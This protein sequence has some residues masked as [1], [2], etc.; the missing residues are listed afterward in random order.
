LNPGS[1]YGMGAGAA[2][3]WIMSQ[4]VFVFSLSVIK[5]IQGVTIPMF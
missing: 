3:L 2:V 4:A 1:L 5:A